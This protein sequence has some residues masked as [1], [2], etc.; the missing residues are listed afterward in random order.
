MTENNLVTVEDN[1]ILRSIIHDLTAGCYLTREEYHSILR[2][3]E[4]AVDRMMREAENDR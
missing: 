2:I 3:L 4:L 1:R